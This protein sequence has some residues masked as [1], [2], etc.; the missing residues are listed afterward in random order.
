MLKNFFRKITRGSCGHQHAHIN[1]QFYSKGVKKTLWLV[2]FLN[3][4][5]AFLKLALGYY[6]KSTSLIAD[7][8]H[9]LADGASNI[10]ALFGMAIAGQSKDHDH[11]YGHKKYETFTSIFIA[12]LLF[13]VCFYILHDSLER[14]QAAQ[15]PRINFFSFIVLGMTI[16]IN[17]VVMVY[18]YR[19]GKELGS[20]ILIADSMHTR[21]DILTSVS[22]LFAFVGV[23]LGYY[24][25]DAVVALAITCF[26]G[27]SAVEILRSTSKVLCDTAV[28]DG[29]EV[30]AI[31]LTV[32]S[33]KKCHKIRTRG[34]KDDIYID[35]HVLVE[36]QMPLVDAHA[37]S[38][39]IEK[40]I[41]RSFTGVT[42]VVVH[43]EPLS[44]EGRHE[45]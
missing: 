25:L 12:F 21:A 44:S 32:P 16:L 20:D 36:D 30:E 35:L 11:P 18:E 26:I 24:F 28:L 6:I 41:K 1:I 23:A 5:V 2:L 14:L 39:Q 17:I 31:V 40:L 45:E 33:V 38:S 10:I 7:G 34:R 43:I 15:S 3:W 42:D 9:S 13:F 19:R 37:V 29:R 22:V 27:F 8:Y 4:F